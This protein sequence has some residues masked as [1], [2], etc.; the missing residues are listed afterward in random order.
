[1]NLKKWTKNKSKNEKNNNKKTTHYPK[2]LISGGGEVNRAR[3]LVRS[4]IRNF[5]MYYVMVR[6]IIK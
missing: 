5:E 4:S 1:M 3:K 2:K 6:K